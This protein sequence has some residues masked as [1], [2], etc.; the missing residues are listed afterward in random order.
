LQVDDT[1]IIP[2]TAS[3][4]P[5]PVMRSIAVI[6][7]VLL[8]GCSLFLPHPDRSSNVLGD[9][10]TPQDG[11]CSLAVA[12]DRKSLPGQIIADGVPTPLIVHV[13]SSIATN[14]EIRNHQSI[15]FAASSRDADPPRNFEPGMSRHE[16]NP[17][18]PIAVI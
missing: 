6:G 16:S 13:P 17:S 2:I 14:R 8:G 1:G 11:R 4:W 12:Q 3:A 5:R 15:Y 18:Q 10:D 7:L 9:A